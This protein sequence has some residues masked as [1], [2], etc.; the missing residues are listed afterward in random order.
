MKRIWTIQHLGGTHYLHTHQILYPDRGRDIP[1]K[2]RYVVLWA[3]MVAIRQIG[4]LMNAHLDFSTLWGNIYIGLPIKFPENILIGL[5]G[6]EICPQNEIR[7]GPSGGG[8]LFSVPILS[9][10]ILRG[11]S[12]VSSYKIYRKSLNARLSY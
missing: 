1:P 5:I 9:A 2:R 10:V 7:N 12:Y 4:F 11:P 6:A 3:C 8:I